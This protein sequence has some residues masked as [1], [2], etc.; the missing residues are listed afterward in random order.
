[1]YPLSGPYRGTARRVFHTFAPCSRQL[2]WWLRTRGGREER[3]SVRN[4][5]PTTHR[6]VGKGKFSKKTFS[7]LYQSNS[8][9]DKILAKSYSFV[10]FTFFHFFVNARISAGF[11]PSS[12]IFGA[13]DSVLRAEHA[14]LVRTSYFLSKTRD[15][16]VRKKVKKVENTKR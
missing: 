12:L 2:P 4:G 9:G 14:P 16:R 8:T 10:F 7:S 3:S 6:R 11:C 5:N 13:N 1:M 15:L